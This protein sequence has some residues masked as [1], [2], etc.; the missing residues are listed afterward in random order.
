MLDKK[1]VLFDCA[2]ELFATRGFKDTNVADI[3][4]RAGFSVGTF[5]NYYSSKDKLSRRY[6]SRKRLI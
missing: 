5:Y 2:K 4:R 3:T 6:S 1:K